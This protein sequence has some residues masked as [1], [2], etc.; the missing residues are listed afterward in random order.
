VWPE[1]RFPLED[2][3]RSVGKEIDELAGQRAMI[4]ETPTGLTAYIDVAGKPVRRAY[5]HA[6]LEARAAE[7]RAAR[8]KSSSPGP[9]RATREKGGS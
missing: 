9:D 2:L 5:S 1:R 3:L 4:A 6:E 8:S 7:A